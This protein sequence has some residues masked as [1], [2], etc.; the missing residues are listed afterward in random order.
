MSTEVTINTFNEND[1]SSI[2]AFASSLLIMSDTIANENFIKLNLKKGINCFQKMN[3]NDYTSDKAEYLIKIV[4]NLTNQISNYMFTDEMI[5]YF[6]SLEVHSMFYKL[7]KH[8]QMLD[9]SNIKRNPMIKRIIGVLM[10]ISRERIC[11]ENIKSG[12][13][14]IA[15]DF[16]N[17]EKFLNQNK[18]NQHESIDL[19]NKIIRFIYAHTFIASLKDDMDR[20]NVIDSLLKHKN[21]LDNAL[22]TYARND[23]N[24]AIINIYLVSSLAFL[25]SD[26]QLDSLK[27]S[28]EIVETLLNTLKK[29]NDQYSVNKPLKNSRFYFT[30]KINVG[31]NVISADTILK[32]LVRIAVNDCIKQKICELNGLEYFSIIL[33][34]S[35]DN[36]EEHRTIELLL[37]LCFNENIKFKIKKD[38]KLLKLIE[39]KSKSS[40]RNSVLDNC[41]QILQMVNYTLEERLENIKLNKSNSSEKHIMISYCHEN[42][43]NCIKLNEILKT[44]GYKTWLD[45]EN[46]FSSLLEGMEKAVG[47]ASIV[48]LCYSDAYK[49]SSNCRLE[50]E[51]S[52]LCGKHIIPIRMQHKYRP[53]GWLKFLIGMKFYVDLSQCNISENDASVVKIIELIDMKL[54][55]QPD[56]NDNTAHTTIT[57]NSDSKRSQIENWTNEDIYKWLNENNLND[58]KEFFKDYDGLSLLALYEMKLNNYQY[59][60]ENVDKEILKKNLNIAFNSKL[61]FFKMLD[62]LI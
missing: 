15:L 25:F 11:I 3:P 60:C 29:T 55:G 52:L 58:F 16:M 62:K 48:L 43:E 4:H 6:L 46:T 24:L 35:V 54:N 9:S 28:S 19:H 2:R 17:N 27:I 57:L 56:A 33:E 8:Y 26:D 59:F 51:Y 50:A 40:Q 20:F 47:N 49:R 10:C 32:C 30:Y 38:E 18:L 12:I 23:N 1:D 61:R 41:K 44:K 13:F 42:K 37:S 5:E 53:D 36:W 14:S 7:L 45:I 39:T 34:H 21:E 22:S 31:S